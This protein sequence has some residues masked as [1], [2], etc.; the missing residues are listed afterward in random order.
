MISEALLRGDH[1][2]NIALRID[3][4]SVMRAAAF[5]LIRNV[6]HAC[7]T[8]IALRPEDNLAA[9]AVEIV[10]A[11]VASPHPIE[12]VSHRCQIPAVVSDV[13]VEVAAQAEIRRARTSWARSWKRRLL[14]SPRNPR[15]RRIVCRQA[16]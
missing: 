1:V 6:L 5:Q 4:N 3:P 16:P 12:H 2:Y 7:G 14:R 11:A 9:S 10:E 13:R 8:V 15:V